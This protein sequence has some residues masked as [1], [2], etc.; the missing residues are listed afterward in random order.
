M[1]VLNWLSERLEN[2]IAFPRHLYKAIGTCPS[3]VSYSNIYSYYYRLCESTCHI[4]YNRQ[5]CD[6]SNYFT[7]NTTR[8]VSKVGYIDS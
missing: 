5:R 7:G 1:K 2:D 4:Y 8:I 3:E 6:F